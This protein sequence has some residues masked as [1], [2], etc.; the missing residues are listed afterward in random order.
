M[1]HWCLWGQQNMS[2]QWGLD[3]Y[4]LGISNLSKATSHKTKNVNLPKGTP[5]LI[6]WKPGQQLEKL[7]PGGL[8]P[9]IRHRHCRLKKD[10]DENVIKKKSWLKKRRGECKQS[11]T[12]S[13]VFVF[14]FLSKFEVLCSQTSIVTDV[15][16]EHSV[17]PQYYARPRELSKQLLVGIIWVKNKRSNTRIIIILY[18][19]CLGVILKNTRI[20]LIFFVC[21]AVVINTTWHSWNE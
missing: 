20:L 15:H 17:W 2:S 16:E 18:S 6:S 9:P 1:L 21:A 4:L 3:H 11:H 5:P 19:E 12:I 8:Q 13:K 7:V 10:D 14:D